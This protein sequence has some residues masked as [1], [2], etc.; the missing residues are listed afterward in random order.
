MSPRLGLRV[1]SP[2]GRVQL[3]RISVDGL[4]ENTPSSQLSHAFRQ[5]RASV[6]LSEG[7]L[8]QVEGLG[9]PVAD[10]GV[11]RPDLVGDQLNLGRPPREVMVTAQ[12][13]ESGR[14]C[15]GSG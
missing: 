15:L 3:K 10:P 2:P 13:G 1:R 11:D 14:G 6:E 5:H 7:F 8:V 4:R 9:K 12:R